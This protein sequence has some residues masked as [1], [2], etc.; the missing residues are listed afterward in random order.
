MNKLVRL[1]AHPSPTK[2]GIR[3]D[4]RTIT[5]EDWMLMIIRQNSHKLPKQVQKQ[6][7]IKI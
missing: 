1:G 4:L 6:Y 7:E 2:A 3:N 5:F